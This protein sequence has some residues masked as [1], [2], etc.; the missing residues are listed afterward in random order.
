MF[1][2][3]KRLERIEANLSHKLQYRSAQSSHDSF[4]PLVFTQLDFLYKFIPTSNQFN[5]RG[6]DTINEDW[7]YGT[8][9]IDTNGFLNIEYKSGQKEKFQTTPLK[10]NKS[11]IEIERHSF[12]RSLGLYNDPGMDG[13]YSFLRTDE[14]AIA[15]YV[16][17]L[18]ILAQNSSIDHLISE[19]KLASSGLVGSLP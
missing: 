6:R 1:A 14:G 15:S 5:V 16:A 3:L 11:L 8:A 17:F 18:P 13:D 9:S 12:I 19:F 2:V 10:F 7:D 4:E